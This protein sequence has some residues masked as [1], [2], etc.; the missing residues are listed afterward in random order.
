MRREVLGM[1]WIALGN[2]HAGG[3]AGMKMDSVLIEFA[4]LRDERHQ[5]SKVL[6][7]FI[8]VCFEDLSYTV[9]MIPLLQEFFLV[10]WRIS[11]DEIL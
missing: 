1:F 7:L 5:L 10:C 9:V 11:L 8:W 3:N 6:S 2:L 4:Y